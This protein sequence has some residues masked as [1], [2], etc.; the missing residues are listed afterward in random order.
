MRMCC[1]SPDLKVISEYSWLLS[2]LS[3]DAAPFNS[4][5]SLLHVSLCVGIVLVQDLFGQP[6]CYSIL[7]IASLSL[8]GDPASQQTSYSNVS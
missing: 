4:S 7:I 6:H 3:R 8:L 5:V 2:S 1:A